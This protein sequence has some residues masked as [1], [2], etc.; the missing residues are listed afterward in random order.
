MNN[1]F[2]QSS[3]LDGL[4]LSIIFI[5]HSLISSLLLTAGSR[6]LTMALWLVK[7]AATIYLMYYFMKKYSLTQETHTYGASFKY[8][9]MISLFSTI[10]CTAYMLFNLTVINPD[11]IETI[12]ETM[13][14]VFE[15]SGQAAALE[16]FDFDRL[17]S[18]IYFV[19]M[20]IYYL[21]WG[22][23]L[24]SI[25]SNY[26]KKVDIFISSSNEDEDI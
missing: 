10:V 11:S 6:F 4:L 5:L 12:K 24:S 7:F 22:I 17:I 13:I 8:G 3:A 9:F 21:V 26:T 15:S 2:L 1:K 14:A 16:Q 19:W 20:P 25:I 23:I 18:N